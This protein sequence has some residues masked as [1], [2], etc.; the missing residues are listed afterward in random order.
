MQQRYLPV[1]LIAFLLSGLF[2]CG[3]DNS[4]KESLPVADTAAVVKDS[5]QQ[6]ASGKVDMVIS[7]IPFPFEILENLHDSHIPFDQKVMNPVS[8]TSK[9]N[10]YNSK[11]LNLGVY[12]ADL[13][14][15]VT[16]EQFQQIG[17]YVKNAKKLADDLNIPFGFNQDMM[18]KY[19]KFRDNKDSL[20]QVVYNSYNEVD[21][22]LKD[23]DRV[24]IAALV[25]TGSW[26]EGLYL[27]TRTFVNADK[28]PDNMGLY[29][30]IGGQ[31]QS[32][33]IVVKLL[34]EYKKDAYIAS[35][36]ED[37]KE[38]TSLYDKVTTNAVMNERQLVFI[39]QKVEKLRNK[40]VE[41][42]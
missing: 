7:D 38:I 35:L 32:L 36:I 5:S 42:L 15:V 34:E 40:I 31:K 19:N 12:G 37:L 16:Y 28:T 14:Y 26:L 29:R 25:V 21:K 6:V 13:A 2:S 10:Q 3:S 33:G 39:N 24:G 23:D 20:T 22:S 4:N 11:A 41:G 1:V 30:T 9:Y 17:A 18:D 27:S 8:N